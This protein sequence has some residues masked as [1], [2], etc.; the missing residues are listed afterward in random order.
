MAGC[1]H[2][3]KWLFEILYGLYKIQPHDIQMY[4]WRIDVLCDVQI[5]AKAESLK[6][7][8]RRSYTGLMGISKLTRFHILCVLY[9]LLC[10]SLQLH[11]LEYKRKSKFPQLFPSCWF[12]YSM[13]EI[14]KLASCCY[15]WSLI[16]YRSQLIWTIQDLR[17]SV[18]WYKHTLS[19]CLLLATNHI[20]N[21]IHLWSMVLLLE[22]MKGKT[23]IN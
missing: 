2:Y 4:V 3:L 1:L 15:C 13:T 19:K 23:Y 16:A 7:P 5:A 10:E 12:S 17:R 18:L 8:D 22:T 6:P 21:S 20:F 9:Q 11:Q 14:H